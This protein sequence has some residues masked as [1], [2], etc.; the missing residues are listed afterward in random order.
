VIGLALIIAA[1]TVVSRVVTT[2]TPLYFL[3][4]GL[5]AA[6]CRRQSGTDHEFSRCDPD[7]IHGGAYQDPDRE[8]GVLRFRVLAVLS[9]FGDDA[10]DQIVRMA[11]VH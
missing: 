2:F 10:Y 11:I 4:Q 5:R 6:C 9:T 1:F 8:C 3:K 7:G